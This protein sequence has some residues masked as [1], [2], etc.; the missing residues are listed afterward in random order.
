MEGRSSSAE[1]VERGRLPWL[2]R[3]ALALLAAV[4]AALNFHP[5][6]IGWDPAEYVWVARAGLLP[7]APYLG[8]V[9]LGRFLGLFLPVGLG[10]SLLSA[11]AFVATVVLLPRTLRGLG[12][13]A[14]AA[15]FA[16]A[17]LASFPVC[18][19]QAGI[20][21]A[22]C[23]QLFLVVLSL[24][25]FTARFPRHL[26]WSGV[27][28]GLAACVHHG[29]TFVLPAFLFRLILPERRGGATRWQRA[30]RWCLPLALLGAADL[31]VTWIAFASV[32]PPQLGFLS[33]L[34]G[35][36][37]YARSRTPEAFLQAVGR[38]LESFFAP[39]VVGLHVVVALLVAV[40]VLV[41]LRRPWSQLVPWALFGGTYALFE[42]LVGRNI[43]RGL[44]AAYL[45]L[46]AAVF[47]GLGLDAF[48]R[49]GSRLGGERVR[50]PAGVLAAVL[51]LCL[52]VAGFSV[53]RRS[54]P[55][56]ELR[57]FV[58]HPAVLASRWMERHLPADAIVVEPLGIDNA[59]LLPSL[60]LRR[61]ILWYRGAYRWMEPY[62]RW[63]PVHPA[64]FEELTFEHLVGPLESG[65][66][67]VALDRGLEA[68][69]PRLE[70]E[71]LPAIQA[72][73]GEG[74][75]PP[76]GTLYRLRL[77]SAPPAGG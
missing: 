30:W 68:F 5:V 56:G 61:P 47:A 8:Y 71:P 34:R 64:L 63:A 50:G 19:R 38:E 42:V 62:E 49:L 23:V 73:A 44:Y 76:P 11:A 69:D 32:A 59:N 2:A 57:E 75:A 4:G 65:R 70:L 14:D 48:V 6:A 43:D 60:H 3:V 1:G 17:L 77:R 40:G 53:S 15:L 52:C 21:E 25:L 20:Q 33:Y 12:V 18:M 36:D 46:P 16:A 26:V 27:V 66:L 74:D 41:A 54:Y 45:A 58:R 31:L 9:L 28:F 39:E 35:I 7:H 10:L 13:R 51:L 24:R 67:V 55:A 29:A 22:Y 72:F 37:L